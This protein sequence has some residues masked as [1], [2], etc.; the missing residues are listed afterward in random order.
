M[1]SGSRTVSMGGSTLYSRVKTSHPISP[2]EYSSIRASR[3]RSTS[4]GSWCTLEERIAV[5]KLAVKLWRYRVFA[6]LVKLGLYTVSE[7]EF[8]YI[9]EPTYP[10]VCINWSAKSPWLSKR[11]CLRAKRW[12]RSL[13]FS[14]KTSN[15][16]W[17]AIWYA[18]SIDLSSPPISVYC[19]A[20]QKL[21][22][23]SQVQKWLDSLPP[24]LLIFSRVMTQSLSRQLYRM[25]FKLF[26]V[27]NI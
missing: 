6:G 7:V 19:N 23:G 26:P 2:C 21:P 1:A 18:I 11:K 25:K 12:S 9:D 14:I 15:S 20:S 24:V 3:R 5:S 10:S 27:E 22:R 13:N 8:V 4:A 16:R 17:L